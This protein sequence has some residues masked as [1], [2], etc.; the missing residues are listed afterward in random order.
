MKTNEACYCNR[1]IISTCTAN[2]YSEQKNCW[3]YTKSSHENKCMH[4]IFDEYCDCV[5]AQM[6]T[7]NKLVV[8]LKMGGV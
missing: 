1:D 4:Y 2:S 6:S 8:S 5:E 3:F 7:A